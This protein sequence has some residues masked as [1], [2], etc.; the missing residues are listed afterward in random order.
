M[1]VRAFPELRGVRLVLWSRPVLIPLVPYLIL[2]VYHN[3]IFYVK[4]SILSHNTNIARGVTGM[5]ALRNVELMRVHGEAVIELEHRGVGKELGNPLGGL[6]EA[7]VC[8]AFN[9]IPAAKGNPG[10]DAT[11]PRTK[12]KYQIKGTWDP[13]NKGGHQFSAI[14]NISRHQFDFVVGVVFNR[15]FSVRG[16]YRIPYEVVREL[17]TRRD[18]TNANQLSCG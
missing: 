2:T 10:V 4:Y 17:T 1:L 16:A 6:T 7:V 15:D 5:G 12:K 9:L 3:I 18:H 8:R 14:R 11:D 13:L